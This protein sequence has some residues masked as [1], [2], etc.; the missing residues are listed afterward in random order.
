MP[1]YAIMRMEKRKGGQITA[2]GRH[3]DRTQPV[4]N[5]D[6]ARTHLNRVLYGDDRPTRELVTEVINEHGGKPRKDAVEG[7]EVLCKTSPQ[8]FAEKDPEKFRE[9]VDAFVEQA[10]QFL[11]D[12]RTG[13]K[14]VK[15]VLHLDEHTPHIHAYKVPIDPEGKLNAKHFMRD[16]EEM[17]RMQDIYYEYMKPLGLE[18]GR[19]RSRATHERIE[20]FYKAIDAP[21]RLEVDHDEIPDPPKVILTEEARKKYKDKVIRAVLKGLEEPHKIMRDQAMLARHERGQREEAERKAEA[22]ERQAAERAE[23][24]DRAAQKEIAEVRREEA[25]RYDKLHESSLRLSDENKRL[26]GENEKMLGER[27]LLY[28]TATKLERQNEELRLRASRYQERLTDIPMHEVL[29]RMGYRGERQGEAHVYLSSQGKVAIRI[30]GQKA[31]DYSRLEVSRNSIDLVIRMR[32]H[33]QGV[34]GFTQ[35][36]AIEFLREEFG[37]SRTVGAVMAHREQ[38][39]LAFFERTRQERERS[40]VPGRGNDPW[41]GARGRAE[42]HDRGSRGGHDDDRGGGRSYTPGGR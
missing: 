28:R 2:S 20:D 31:E 14:L 7:I 17:E 5:A 29:E 10:M 42:D 3:N 38:S 34:E 21:V 24:A 26:H 13:G 35:E 9:K 37:D 30:E 8:F 32:R 19:R 40:L 18:R 41:R 22:A 4:P 15:A 36:Q 33:H 6:P 25:E 11:R 16:R 23:A 1:S 12:E 27:T 39:V